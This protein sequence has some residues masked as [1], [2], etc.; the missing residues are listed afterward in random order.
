[1]RNRNVFLGLVLVTGVGVSL[2]ACSDGPATAPAASLAPA[3]KPTAA[4]GAASYEMHYLENAINQEE[5]ILQMAQICGA[6]PGLHPELAAFCQNV[7]GNASQAIAIMQGYLGDWYGVQN[8]P[9]LKSP[10]QHLLANL[11]SLEGADFETAYLNAMIQKDQVA[12]REGQRC[13][14]RATHTLLIAF[15]FNMQ[16]AETQEITQMRQWLCAWYGAC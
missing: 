1:M 12:V 3:A 9:S 15:C 8:T 11:Q 4:G 16:Y 13:Y 14:A 6:K 2:A 7:T 10:D 5:M